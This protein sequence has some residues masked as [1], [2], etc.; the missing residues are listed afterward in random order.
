MNNENNTRVYIAGKITG[1]DKA[2]SKAMFD[3]AK[4]ILNDN[5]YNAISPFDVCEENPEKHWSDYMG[6]C[7]SELL[8]CNAIVMLPNWYDSR[9]AR[10]EYAVA[11]EMG[12]QVVF[13]TIED[14]C[15]CIDTEYII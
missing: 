15:I 12:M 14:D 7:H 9:G 8:R 4:D 13:A 6:E 3:V 11:R 5:D 2:E 10:I 1:M